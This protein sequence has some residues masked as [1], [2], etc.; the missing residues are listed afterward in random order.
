MNNI[1]CAICG[2]ALCHIDEA[3]PRCLPDFY[4]SRIRPTPPRC[5][6]CNDTGAVAIRSRDG[7]YAFAGPVPDD[8]KGYADADCWYCDSGRRPVH[9]RTEKD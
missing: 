4:L 6:K 5:H 1:Q 8:A 3:C 7:A 9:G 2:H